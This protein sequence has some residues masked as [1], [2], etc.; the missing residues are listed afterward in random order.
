M[1]LTCG[2]MVASLFCGGMVGTRHH[3]AYSLPSGAYI[4]IGKS[5]SCDI[6][7]T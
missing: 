7:I 4:P 6:P 1:S 3:S 5:Y 2:A